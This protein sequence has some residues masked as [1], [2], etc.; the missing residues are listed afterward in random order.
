MIPKRLI[1]AAALAAL[2]LAGCASP[3]RLHPAADA[4]AA[5][6]GPPPDDNL[7]AVAWTQTALEHD[8]VYREVFRAA[9]EQLLR[10]LADPQRDALPHGERA[11]GIDPAT[12]APAVIV[13]IDETLLDNSPYQARLVRTG[14]AYDE[15]GWSQ[16][17]REKAARP[18]PGAV[19]FAR[20]AAEH[21]VAVFFLSNRA[22]SLDGVTLDNLRDAGFPVPSPGVFLGLGTSVPGCTQS[23]SDKGCRRRQVGRDHRVLLQLGDQIGDFVDVAANSPE[24][25]RAALAPYADWIGERWFVLPNPTYGSWEPALFGND[26]SLPAAKR[27][28][29]KLDALRY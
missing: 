12:L 16:W 14:Q 26:R 4:R 5:T 22:Q 10:A 15:A 21:G 25:R 27:R 1:P 18:L 11:A 29:A 20:L 24:G 23:G 19:A 6:S 28:Q 13:D 8:L 3:G 7:N 2:L 17:C 9:G